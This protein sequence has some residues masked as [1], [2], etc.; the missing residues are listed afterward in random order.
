M[1]IVRRS[2]NARSDCRRSMYFANHTTSRSLLRPSSTREPSGPPSEVIE[3]FLF[4]S[5]V[6]RVFA[7]FRVSTDRVLA[8]SPAVLSPTTWRSCA[9]FFDVTRL[10]LRG[11]LDAT[12]G[13]VP[14]AARGFCSTIFRMLAAFFRRLGVRNAVPHSLLD[15]LA[16]CRLLH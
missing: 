3:S 12:E 16:V 4:G 8:P 13:V 1:I 7:T 15:D 9:A 11:R 10:F 2:R 5:A 14:P 6:F